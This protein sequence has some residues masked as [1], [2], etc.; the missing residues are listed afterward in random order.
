MKKDFPN[1]IF[2][3]RD[4]IFH[5]FMGY[6][7]KRDAEDYIIHKSGKGYVEVFELEGDYYNFKGAEWVGGKEKREDHGETFGSNLENQG[8]F[9][10]HISF[11]L[12]Y[13]P[14]L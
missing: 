14:F 10:D 5:T 8:V 13:I 4:M 9:K 7:N 6:D 1:V 11:I 2:L 12:N 3:A